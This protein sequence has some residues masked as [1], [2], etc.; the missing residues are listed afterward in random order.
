MNLGEL[1]SKGR[2]T[3]GF[4]AT[5]IGLLLVTA[6]LKGFSILQALGTG[7]TGAPGS[8]LARPAPWIESLTNGQVM[9][10]AG[11]FE[12][13]VVSVV[14]LLPDRRHR[15]A[16]VAW[17]GG[18]FASYHVGLWLSPAPSSCG[19]LGV[20]GGEASL[21]GWTSEFM[22]TAMIAYLL[23]GSYLGLAW[24]GRQRFACRPTPAATPGDGSDGHRAR[25]H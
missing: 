2:G 19:C 7:A 21:P 6:G 14:L 18:L 22:V 11:V 12:L 13:A 25:P 9:F 4:L 8:W 5:V 10:V 23:V 15:L 3:D 20:P 17:V 24:R 16:V 1:T